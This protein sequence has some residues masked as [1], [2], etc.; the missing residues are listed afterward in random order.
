[1]KDPETGIWFTAF[2]SLLEARLMAPPSQARPWTRKCE[3][4]LM[5]DSMLVAPRAEGLILIVAH[6]PLERKAKRERLRPE[7]FTPFWFSLAVTP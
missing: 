6:A 4:S 5:F 2:S 3:M 1:M 7:E